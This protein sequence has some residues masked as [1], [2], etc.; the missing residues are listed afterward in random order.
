MLRAG[1]ASNCLG[2]QIVSKSRRLSTPHGSARAKAAASS[3]R[4]GRR[5]HQRRACLRPH[6]LFNTLNSACL[7]RRIAPGG[8]NIGELGTSCRSLTRARRRW[9]RRELGLRE[10]LGMS[11]AVQ[12]RLAFH[13]ALRIPTGD[14]SSSIPRWVETP[15]GRI[16]PLESGGGSPCRRAKQWPR[17][18]RSQLGGGTGAHR[19]LKDER[20]SQR[21]SALVRGR[22]RK[23][24]A[25]YGAAFARSRAL[26]PRGRARIDI[27]TARRRTEVHGSRATTAASQARRA[28]RGAARAGGHRA[29]A[30]ERVRGVRRDKSP[31]S[32]PRSRDEE[33][34]RESDARVLSKHRTWGRVAE[35]ATEIT[36]CS[37]GRARAG[38][39][40]LDIDAGPGWFGVV[41]YLSTAR[42]RGRPVRTRCGGS[43][44]SA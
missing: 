6:W 13:R 18:A 11:D 38:L 43:S 12:D 36:P 32:Y 33:P 23:T 16:D 7:M 21:R 28:A 8:E 41:A 34:W 15:V 10:Y 22:T 17:D 4:S 9:P 5:A 24:H 44:D 27:P 14:R 37:G 30:S 31:A 29:P 39:L 20:R 26:G 40:L 19:R 42:A 1:F 35:A 3:S 2:N 25:A